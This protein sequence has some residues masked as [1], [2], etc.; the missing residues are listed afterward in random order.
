MHGA[1]M[2]K[3]VYSLTSMLALALV[4]A[5]TLVNVLSGC[6]KPSS[7]ATTITISDDADSGHFMNSVIPTI[8]GTWDINALA[9]ST[10]KSVYTVQRLNKDRERFLGL[11][12]MLGPMRTHSLAHGTT[13]ILSSPSGEVEYAAYSAQLSYAKG[14]A[15]ISVDAMKDHGVWEIVNA[16]V[17]PLSSSAPA[18]GRVA[19]SML[20]GWKSPRA[21]WL[22]M[23][24]PEKIATVKTA[25]IAYETGFLDGYYA[26]VLRF[27]LTGTSP[28]P[29]SSDAANQYARDMMAAMPTFSRPY[30]DYAAAITADC[31]KTDC[32]MGFMWILPCMADEPMTTHGLRCHIDVAPP[33][34]SRANAST[35]PSP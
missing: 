3:R 32:H 16:S 17:L 20:H 33:T 11:A 31:L 21:V 4:L 9:A 34:S 2:V 12:K 15:T 14:T 25:I 8:F 6:S 5:T 24:E 30:S 18:P 29:Q 23:S 22:A 1:K 7:P 26:P 28:S 10:D 27:E 19:P 13:R 35:P